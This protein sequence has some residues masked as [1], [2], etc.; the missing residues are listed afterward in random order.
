MKLLKT[1]LLCLLLFVLPITL[2]HADRSHWHGG[3]L[4]KNNTVSPNE[5]AER[6]RKELGGRILAIETIQR[7]NKTFYRIKILTG[8]GVVR[9]INVN[10]NTGRI[11]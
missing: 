11:R 7:K 4:A 10:A 1:S 3:L 5:A 6:V 9:V 8:R 2:S